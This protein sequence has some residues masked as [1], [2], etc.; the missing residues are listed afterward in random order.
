MR[1]ARPAKRWWQAER[2]FRSWVGSVQ[3]PA[4][5]IRRRRRH[6]GRGESHA[7]RAISRCAPPD[8]TINAPWSPVS[9]SFAFEQLDTIDGPVRRN[10][11]VHVVADL[12]RRHLPRLLVESYVGHVTFRIV[13]EFHES[14]WLGR[15][16]VSYGY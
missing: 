15:I 10:V 1:P 7:T 14:R 13:T 5:S 11:N 6:E 3:R 12:E 4:F 16:K 8:S 9:C 2:G